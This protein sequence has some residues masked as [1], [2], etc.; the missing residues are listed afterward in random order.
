MGITDK[1]TGRLKKA[2]GDLT[3]DASMRQQGRREE[4][5]GDELH[6]RQRS[7]GDPAAIA[8]PRGLDDGGGGHAEKLLE[9]RQMHDHRFTEPLGP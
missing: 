1:I 3:D 6:D 5:G 4:D 9:R 2:A 8:F 7:A